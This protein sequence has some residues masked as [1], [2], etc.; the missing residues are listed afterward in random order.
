MEWN[1]KKMKEY[2]LLFACLLFLVL[3]GSSLVKY[4][5][6]KMMKGDGSEMMVLI[7]CI[8]KKKTGYMRIMNSNITL[9]KKR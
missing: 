8:R 7:S 6:T 3:G 4:G 1:I 2:V 9:G 5:W